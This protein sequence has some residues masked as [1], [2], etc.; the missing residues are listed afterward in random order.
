MTQATPSIDEI[1]AS[2]KNTSLPT[3]LVEGRDDMTIYRWIEDRLGTQKAN[4]LPCG[5]R[6]KLFAVYKRQTEFR[7]LKCAFLADRDMWLFDTTCSKYGSIVF[8]KGYSIENDVLDG[9]HVADLLSSSEQKAFQDTAASLS[10]W[11]AFE[12]QE[13]RAGRPYFVHV[14]PDQVVPPGGTALDPSF[15]AKRGYSAVHASRARSIERHFT[16][17]FRGKG[18]LDLYVRL[19]SGRARR[20]KFSKH[21]LLEIGTKL[22]SRTHMNRLIRL[23]FRKLN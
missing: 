11:F 5:N 10:Q 7:H 13:Y 4:V 15:L 20:S 12:V 19:L 14:H 8:T 21:N 17:R 18:L 9:S 2:L 22:D 23:V 3:V 16:V 1:V 6:D